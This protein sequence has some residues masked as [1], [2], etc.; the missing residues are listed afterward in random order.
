M[1]TATQGDSEKATPTLVDYFV[2]RRGASAQVAQEVANTLIGAGYSAIVQDFDIPYTANFVVAMHQALKRCQHLIVLLSKDYDASTFTLTEVASFIAA[3]SRSNG[4]RRLVVLRVEDCEP[5]G[6]FAGIVFA[7]LVGVVDPK[8]RQARILAAAEG[9]STALP[10]RA[11][12]F[13][14]VP[15]RNPAFCGRE[16][17]LARLQAALIGPDGAPIANCQPQAIIGQGGVGKSSLAAEY[18][19]KH[20]KNYLGIWWAAAQSRLTLVASLAKLA[21]HLDPRLAAAASGPSADLEQLAAK[22]LGL[23]PDTPLPWLLIYDN[24][25]NPNTL[26]HLMPSASAHILI[27]SRWLDWHGIAAEV[28]VQVFTPEVAQAYLLERTG[29]KDKAAAARLADAVAYLPLALEH[30]GALCKRSGITFDDY[31]ARIADFIRVK[32]AGGTYPESVFGTFSQAIDHAAAACPHTEKLMAILAFLSPDDISSALIGPTVMDVVDRAAALEA[33]TAV[34]L[35]SVNSDGSIRIH[36]LVQQVMRQRIHLT[37]A[38]ESTRLTIY[39]MLK[40]AFSE[41]K[42]ILGDQIF[43]DVLWCLHYDPNPTASLQMGYEKPP[44]YD[45]DATFQKRSDGVFLVFRVLD[46]TDG[47]PVHTIERRY[48]W[49]GGWKFEIVRNWT[50]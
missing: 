50:N 6:I 5:E 21:T 44:H 13:Q 38:Y 23:L 1:N 49:E 16:D 42:P 7:D 32:P 46:S 20:A 12:V 28:P 40:H 18:A 27:T 26:S 15:S 17:G 47:H 3:A 4:E 37:N 48:Y 33:L 19:Y 36:R 29:S 14:D 35:V 39:E 34:A 9:R 25:E 24:V 11:K 10:R 41:E 45:V 22:A 31:R 8:E 2:S 30:A 43:E